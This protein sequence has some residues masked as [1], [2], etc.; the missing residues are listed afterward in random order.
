M[1][2]RHDTAHVILGRDAGY[3][4]TV[5]ASMPALRTQLKKLPWA[6]VS[7]CPA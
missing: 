2:A 3:V 1:H 7:P 5:K 6:R 4:S